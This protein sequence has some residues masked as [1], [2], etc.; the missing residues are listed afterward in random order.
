MRATRRKPRMRHNPSPSGGPTWEEARMDV[1]GS[2]E[3]H[4]TELSR[5]GDKLNEVILAQALTAQRLAIY[6]AGASTGGAA[7]AVAAMKLLTAKGG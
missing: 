7:L 3:V 4:E 2:I 1:F 6:L 5:Q